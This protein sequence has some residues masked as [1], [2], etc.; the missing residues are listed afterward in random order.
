MS[1][2]LT[3]RPCAGVALVNHAGDA[4]IGHRKRKRGSEALDARS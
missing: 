2:D 4:F 1:K 3:Y